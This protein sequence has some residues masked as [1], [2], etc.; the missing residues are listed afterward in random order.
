MKQLKTI[1]KQANIFYISKILSKFL[2]YLSILLL[3]SFLSPDEFGSFQLMHTIIMTGVFISLFGFQTVLDRYIPYL[4]N[5]QNR[6]EKNKYLIKY[7][8]IFTLILSILI[9]CLF[10]LFPEY[11]TYFFNTGTVKNN[12]LSGLKILVFLIPAFT[13]IQVNSSIFR[14]YKNLFFPSLIDNL[15]KPLGKIIIATILLL[16]GTTFLHWITT[17]T[18]FIILLSLFSSYLLYKNFLKEW[19]KKTKESPPNKKEFFSFTWPLVIQNLFEIISSNITAILIGVFV[20]VKEVGVHSIYIA[21]VSIVGFLGSAIGNIF[22]PI[23]SENSFENL[24]K[25]KDLYKRVSKWGLLFSGIFLVILYFYGGSIIKILFSNKYSVLPVSLAILG[26]GKLI[27]NSAGPYRQ[28][29]SALGKTNWDLI[30]S[31]IK[32]ISIIVLSIILIPKFSI[33]GAAA[34]IA[35]SEIIIS[36]FGAFLVKHHFDIHPFSSTTWNTLSVIVSFSII[37]WG[38]K[39][40]LTLEPLF[41]AIGVIILVVSFIF[42]VYI[43]KAFDDID[44]FL[45]K[46]LLNRIKKTFKLIL[47]FKN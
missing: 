5:K 28:V 3:T 40:Y 23:A 24:T 16:F 32:T 36:I 20:A 42:L 35:G 9:L 37:A 17:Y 29:I 46:K 8:Y 27:N 7:I 13:L 12:F 33:A 30:L 44:W 45:V 39:I 22:K 38:L 21:T 18:L 26:S 10:F 19:W 41:I 43:F 2:G 47:N 25:T 14:G 34:G 15:L 31:I 4:K 1:A 11:I 6:L